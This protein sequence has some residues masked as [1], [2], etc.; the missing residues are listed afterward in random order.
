MKTKLIVLASLLVVSFAIAVLALNASTWLSVGFWQGI[1]QRVAK[2]IAPA[3]VEAQTHQT[4]WCN[5]ANTGAED[6]LT[7][8]TGYKICQPLKILYHFL[9]SDKERFLIN[10]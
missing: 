2:V 8:A 6:G 10:C 3:T 9:F 7:K 5:P 4:I 1:E